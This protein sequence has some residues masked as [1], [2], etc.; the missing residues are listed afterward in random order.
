MFNYNSIISMIL[1]LAAPRLALLGDMNNKKWCNGFNIE[2]RQSFTK[3][4]FSYDE[5][6]KS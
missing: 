3:E 4:T 6:L 5:H 1:G 2:F